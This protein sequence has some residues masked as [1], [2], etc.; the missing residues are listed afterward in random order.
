[1]FDYFLFSETE[2]MSGG[3]IVEI[4]SKGMLWDKVLGVLWIPLNKISGSQTVC[5]DRNLYLLKRF[6]C[7]L[8]CLFNL[9][10]VR[11]ELNYF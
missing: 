1:M 3:L 10:T 2:S 11:Y 7:N 4:H 8:V 5:I 6:I 9:L